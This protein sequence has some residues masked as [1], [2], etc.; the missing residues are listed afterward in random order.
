MYKVGVGNAIFERFVI[1]FHILSRFYPPPEFC[2]PFPQFLRPLHLLP[3]LSPHLITPLNIV[4]L[5]HILSRFH[6]SAFLHP[7]P[8]FL[9]HLRLLSHF[10]PHLI[11]S[12]FSHLFPH[13]LSSAL[14]YC[15]SPPALCNPSTSLVTP[16]PTSCHHAHPFFCFVNH[17]TTQ[18]RNIN[19]M[20]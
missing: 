12:S 13:V 1:P 17:H 10:Y 14:T 3:H 7:F 5:F 8:H 18:G 19:A 15:H 9:Q 16:S 4:T 2:H 11:T 6:P 20:F